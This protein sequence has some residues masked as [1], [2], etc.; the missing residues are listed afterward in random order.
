MSSYHSVVS[1]DFLGLAELPAKPRRIGLT[2]VLDK[3]VSVEAMAGILASYSDFIDIWK[4]GWG[5][6][7]LEPR[8]AEKMALLSD[9]GMQACVGGTLL[10]ISW[11]Q[12][13]ADDLLDWAKSAG[14]DA[15]EVSR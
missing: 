12:G 11:A 3:G 7:Y 4:F 2:H 10:E 13:S 14:F 8:L 5:T 15:V 9:H 1:P 6:S